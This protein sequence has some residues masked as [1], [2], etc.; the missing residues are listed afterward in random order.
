MWKADGHIDAYNIKLTYPVALA[1]GY[2][3]QFVSRLLNKE[4]GLTPFRVKVT[5][6]TRYHDISKAK[7]VLGY[8]P[9]VLLEQGIQH[10]L[11]WIYETHKE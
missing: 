6:A 8:T 4:P 11:D 9:A 2:L 1:A 5:C 7:A 10:T 3:L